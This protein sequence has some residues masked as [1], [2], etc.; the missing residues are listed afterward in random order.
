MASIEEQLE[1][2]ERGVVDCIS[3]D[4]LIKKLK[5]SQDSGI[6]LKVKPVLTQLLRIF[7]LVILFCS[8]N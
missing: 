8:R 3:R 4:E 7:I 1:L 2:I 5:K 6:P